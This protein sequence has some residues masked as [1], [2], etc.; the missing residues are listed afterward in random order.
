[1]KSSRNIFSVLNETYRGYRRYILILL[2]LGI[3]SAVLDG[4]GINALI[5]LVSFLLGDTGLPSDTISQLMVSLF[6]FFGA[7]F[8]FR[9]VLIFTAGLFVARA[10]ILALFA[11][12]RGRVNAIYLTSEVRTLYHA[13]LRVSWA[14]MLRQKGGFIQNTV[15]WDAKRNAQLLDTVVQFIQSAIGALIYLTVAVS[16]SP[17]ITLVTII[18]G[19]VIL[20]LFRPIRNLARAYG[21]EISLTEKLLAHHIGEHVHGFKSVKASGAAGRVG[22]NAEGALVRMHDAVAN[23]ILMQG[24]G[25]VIIQPLSFLF[26]IGIFAF[27]YT[28]GNFNLA[29]FA[30]I[31]YLIQKI[32]VYLESTQGA[33]QSIT[34]LI[35]YAENIL[36]FK[37][38]A[39]NNCESEEGDKPFSFE[40]AIEFKNVSLAYEGRDPVLSRVSFTVPKGGMF[41]IVGHSGSGK[42][43]LADIILRLFHPTEGEVLLDGVPVE[44]IRLSEWRRNIAYV[45]QDAFLLHA[46]IRDNIRFYDETIS[47][48]DI[49]RAARSA[50]IY[51]DI[52][53]LPQGFDT[54]LGDR[55]AT[56]SGG[57]RQR[58][59]LARALARKPQVL[60]LDEVTSALDSE[61]ERLIQVV[62]DELRG[63]ITLLVIA[64]RMSTVVNAD[65]M[66]VLEGGLIVE[67]GKPSE[68]LSDPTSYVSRMM[69]LQKSEGTRR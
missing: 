15:F 30:A 26:I 65:R 25:S 17:V 5:P 38:E 10:I 47:D 7:P 57:Q 28:S 50:H 1:M 48:V 53:R 21:G 67:E 12:F 35:P 18:L 34:Q 31:L 37:R 63:S 49:E 6:G 2:G 66:L 55:G 36:T 44:R 41:A 54:V 52:M 62:I 60:V 8:T 29:S 33:I 61:L 45:S 43:S 68:M 19:A 9:Y 40:R 14:Y 11:F 24:I 13:A 27:A 56:L 4:V 22:E 58:V 20:V 16:I 69:A 23:S 39:G 59:A 42:T 51:E 3:L 32:F 64:H 46:S